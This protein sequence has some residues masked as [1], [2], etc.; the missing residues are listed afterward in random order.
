MKPSRSRIAPVPARSPASSREEG[1]VLL[2]GV[3]MIAAVLAL[4]L[5]VA[6]ATSV[7]LDLKT[8]TGLADAAAAAAAGSADDGGYFA[9]ETSSA[10]PGV[11][12]Q[13]GVAAAARAD[14]ASQPDAP[15][16]ARVVN[17]TSPDG[18][19]AVVTLEARSVPPFLP[20]GIAGPFGITIR[21]TGSSLAAVTP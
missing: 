1:E 14:L 7:Y 6:A 21:A 5:V 15:A 13:E 19:T 16:G 18:A 10:G 9:G 20:W 4:V 3:G 2:L 11:L 12:S 8:L 17:A